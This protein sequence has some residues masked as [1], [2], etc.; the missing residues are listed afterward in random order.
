MSARAEGYLERD[1]VRLHYVE[2]K[3]DQERRAPIFLLHGLSSNALFWERL[4]ARLPG[5]RLVALD[6]RSHG[7]SDRPPNGYGADVVVADAAYAIE[8]LGLG[9][10]F[11]AGHSWGAAIAL[12][13]AGTRPDLV[14]GLAFID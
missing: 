2:W 12:E 10:T 8:Q 5:R 13:L 3:P 11:V 4:A 6:Q 1:G 9:R 14:A 7:L